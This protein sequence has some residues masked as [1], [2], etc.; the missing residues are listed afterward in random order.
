MQKIFI[1]LTALAMSINSNAQQDTISLQE[2]IVTANKYE[3]KQSE[4]AKVIT[5]IN[6]EQLSHSTGKT[7]GELLNTIA[8]TN[9]IGSYSN[10]GTNQTISMRGASTGN[11]LVLIDGIPA[12]D[13]SAISNYYDINFIPTELVERIE[14][15]KGGQSTLYGSDAVAGVV[16]IITKKASN[17]IF[18]GDAVAGFGS[19]GTI[20]TQLN[21]NG[22]LKN[23]DYSV[24]ASNVH[25]NGFSSA[26]DSTKNAGFD[27]DGFDER[28]VR[29]LYGIK[30]G[31]S[32]KLK[33]NGSYSYYKTNVDAG[34]Y[35]DDINFI[36]S[37]ANYQLGA[38]WNKKLRNGLLNIN[39]QFSQVRRLYI[40]DSL[41]NGSP[42]AEYSKGDYVGKTHFAEIYTSKKYNNF[43]IVGGA[44]LRINE[45]VQDYKGVSMWGFYEQPQLKKSMNQIS[46]YASS[47]YK[48][49]IFLLESGLRFN[50]H[51]NYGTNFTFTLNPAV[52]LGKNTRA[53]A[54]IYS[55][56]KAPTL[57]QLFDPLAGNK[58]LDPEKN[59][60]QELGLD[61]NAVKYFKSRLV[62]FNRTSKN[63]IMW[64][65][66]PLSWDGSYL[67]ASKQHDHGVEAEAQYNKGV[68]GIK[69]N[70]TYTDG[71]T[72]SEYDGT[73]GYMGKDTTYF[74]L[75]RIPKHVLNLQISCKTKLWYSS[76]QFRMAS[77]QEEYVW[78]SAPASLKGYT[79]INATV[80][81]YLG[82]KLKLFLQLNNLTN[83]HFEEQKGYN[84]AGFH[85]MSGLSW[86]F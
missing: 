63:T 15:L 74:N 72:T 24:S 8:G 56:Y 47:V 1:V 53:F 11:V 77:K 27:K 60:V 64:T 81:R 45:T 14:I 18:Q 35:T 66:T 33:L 80:E 10:L 83:T 78:G 85:F 23:S 50:K 34:A 75:W 52:S 37:S 43:S 71:S 17:K 16:N 30:T 38:G 84:S 79:L 58:S 26:N 44:D 62:V 20:R 3:Q 21:V 31:A 49:K 48:H 59:F 32:S 76:L 46:L 41:G 4:T 61:L 69:L 67:N 54:N 25:S 12:N 42:V 6:K 7:L 39:Y 22:S 73:G 82:E 29:V 51:S 13:P 68:A 57:Y 9:V 19:F 86:K 40:D 36:S 28:T 55:S 70:Y 65:Y 5:V 2:A